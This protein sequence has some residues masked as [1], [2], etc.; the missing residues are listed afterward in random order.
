M[1]ALRAKLELLEV[2]LENKARACTVIPSLIL[3][4]YLLACVC[5]PVATIVFGVLVLYFAYS[6]RRLNE[7]VKDLLKLEPLINAGLTV[8]RV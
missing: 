2:I 3:L 4:F 5:P 6:V 8:W 1:R 7:L